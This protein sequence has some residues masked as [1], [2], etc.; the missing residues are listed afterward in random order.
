MNEKFQAIREQDLSENEPISN[1][2]KKKNNRQTI[3]KS[4]L[5]VSFVLMFIFT[6]INLF[7][8][9]PTE[10]TF[11]LQKSFAKQFKP[12]KSY[13]STID[14]KATINK[15]ISPLF[16]ESEESLVEDNTNILI[17]AVRIGHYKTKKIEC[18][19]DTDNLCFSDN[20]NSGTA[21]IIKGSSYLSEKICNNIFLL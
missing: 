10:K 17:N 20:Y 9:K 7:L 5:I 2:S 12:S 14:L 13:S 21:E 4:L 19:I 15:M 11:H 18:G 16:E 3:C 8:I 6:L 1:T